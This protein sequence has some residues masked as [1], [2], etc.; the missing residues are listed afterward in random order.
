MTGMIHIAVQ[1]DIK[2]YLDEM[3]NVCDLPRKLAESH[4][5]RRGESNKTVQDTPVSSVRNGDVLM[6]GDK[7]F[8]RVL[9]I[10]DAECNIMK[11]E[12][13]DRLLIWYSHYNRPGTSKDD[14][15]ATSMQERSSEEE[16]NESPKTDNDLR[17][18]KAV[19]N[20]ID[21]G[22][23]PITDSQRS[24]WRYWYVQRMHGNWPPPWR[25]LP[26]KAN[27]QV[28]LKLWT[29]ITNKITKKLDEVQGRARQMPDPDVIEPAGKRRKK[30][31][32]P[33]PTGLFR[34]FKR[35]LFTLLAVAFV[36]ISSVIYTQYEVNQM[37]ETANANL[38]SS[39]KVLS[40]HEMRLNIEEKTLENMKGTIKQ[41][42]DKMAVL[43][44]RLHADEL[45]AEVS[46]IMNS[47]FQQHRRIING[48]T[49]L[50]QNKL[51]AALVN[52]RAMT[53]TLTELRS[54][55]E[56]QGMRI[57]ITKFDDIFNL[58]VSHAAYPNGNIQN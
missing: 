45:V 6:P 27:G 14:D 38:D 42:I 48:F 21:T 30:R 34:R 25:D 22:K 43:S 18:R 49:A 37:A 1:T 10:M 17:L 33:K 51:P 46:A 53:T 55:M 24:D 13:V 35:F 9:D 32:K 4:V 56:R 23:A 16:I 50:T 52:M 3:D 26:K 41:I 11:E 20:G 57:G 40:K 44:Q 8:Q 29:M 28:D 19:D 7:Y 58:D 36:A 39:I 15:S 31:S 47:F 54:K 2:K 12:I 5:W